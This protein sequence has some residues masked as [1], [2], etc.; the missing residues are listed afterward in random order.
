MN[1]ADTLCFSL[2]VLA[3]LLAFAAAQHPELGKCFGRE[4]LHSIIAANGAEA[5]AEQHL[6]RSCLRKATK[7]A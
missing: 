7:R 2:L 3:Q 1:F 5:A 4:Q 6:P